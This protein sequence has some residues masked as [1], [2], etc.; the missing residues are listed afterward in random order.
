MHTG[1]TNP[2]RVAERRNDN[3]MIQVLDDRQI[4]EKFLRNF[5]TTWEHSEPLTREQVVNAR[6]IPARVRG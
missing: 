6:P 1:S 2:S 3:A 5:A 4:T